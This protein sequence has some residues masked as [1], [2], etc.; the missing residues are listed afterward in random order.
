MRL[1]RGVT[2]VEIVIVTIILG[3]LALIIVPQFSNAGSDLKA[4]RLRSHLGLVRRQLEMYKIEHEHF[5]AAES[6]ADFVSRM[7]LMTRPDGSF[8]QN[9]RGGYDL[10]PYLH[11]IPRNPYT[12]GNRVQIGGPPGQTSADWYYDPQSGQFF[13]N[14]PIIQ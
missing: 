2:L 14:R 5:P 13:A 11:E 1:L 6:E 7:T 9:R 10:G 4:A 12:G 8:S 3:T